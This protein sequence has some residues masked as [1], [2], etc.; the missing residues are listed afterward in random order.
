MLLCPQISGIYNFPMV[1][2]V[3]LFCISERRA[4]VIEEFLAG[5]SLWFMVV[6]DDW[7]DANGGQVAAARLRAWVTGLSFDEIKT[8]HATLIK[9]DSAFG[10]DPIFDTL[11]ML[12]LYKAVL[13]ARQAGIDASEEG[14]VKGSSCICQLLPIADHQRT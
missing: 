9:S 12:G 1:E 7:G 13:A 3:N 10:G 2:L 11:E 5:S 8:L 4:Q 14:S 6:A